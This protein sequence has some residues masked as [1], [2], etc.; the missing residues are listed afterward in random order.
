VDVVMFA[1]MLMFGLGTLFLYH[2]FDRSVVGIAGLWFILAGSYVMESGITQ[3]LVVN[4]TIARVETTPHSNI[5]GL[6][7]IV[8]GALFLVNA[9]VGGEK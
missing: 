2:L 6:F 4:A 8:L 9:A 5:I 7:L 3:T 1:V